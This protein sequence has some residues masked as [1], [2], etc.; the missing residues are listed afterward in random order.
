MLGKFGQWS[1]VPWTGVGSFAPRG[2]RRLRA[3]LRAVAIAVIGAVCVL[4]TNAPAHM[5]HA[6]SSDGSGL[7]PVGD[8]FNNFLLKAAFPLPTATSSDIAFWGNRA[9]AGNYAGFRIFDIT[10]EQPTLLADVVCDGA[11]GDPSVWDRDDDG[12]AD[13]LILSVD[14]TMTGPQCG[15]APA[16]HDDPNGWEGL[17]IFDVEDPGNVQQ[18]ATVYQDC[19]SHTNTVI[20]RPS[21][22]RLLVLN[23]SYPLRPGPT[24][25][26]VRG[27][28]A[29]RD[30]L[31]VVVQVV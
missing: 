7:A 27:P 12:T 18:I 17:R 8:V 11:Q 20:P 25:G 14:R 9:Y 30:P 29:G 15:A 31:H 6:G 23:A 24:C 16:A 19:G 4:P 22:D 21:E 26:P 3:S 1:G 2:T 5:Q 13:L 28:Q 10:N